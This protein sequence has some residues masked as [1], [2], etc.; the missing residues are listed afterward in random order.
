MNHKPMPLFFCAALLAAA[1]LSACNG[2]DDDDTP[3]PIPIP[4]A[5][6]EVPASAA[7]SPEAYSRYALSLNASETAEPLGLDKVVEAPGSES[8]EPLDLN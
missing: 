3:V 5:N 6:T 2:S 1:G 8:A 7:A 4:V